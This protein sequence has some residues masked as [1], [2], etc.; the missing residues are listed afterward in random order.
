ME[1]GEALTEL[2][3]PISHLSVCSTRL[4]SGACDLSHTSDPEVVLPGVRVRFKGVVKRG[5]SKKYSGS[6]V[7]SEWE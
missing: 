4:A 3:L 1:T 5:V 7:T 2:Q 6:A